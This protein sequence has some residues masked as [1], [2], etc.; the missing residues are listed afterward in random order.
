MPTTR[1]GSM[2]LEVVIASG[3]AAVLAMLFAQALSS[4][5]LERRHVERRAIALQE[6]A[7]IVERVAA[8]EWSQITSEGVTD[9]GL[10][11][12]IE[13]ILPAAAAHLS[14][15]EQPGEVPAKQV[16]VEIQW[17]GAAGQPEPPVRLSYWA[18]PRPA[19]GAP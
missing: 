11:P 7:N 6:A 2:L 5:A 14:V 3:L 4:V 9:I 18:Y 1:R 16:R 13:H 19:G 17:Q 8:L 15:E 10:S 12:E